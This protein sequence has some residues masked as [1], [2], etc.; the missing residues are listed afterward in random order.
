MVGLAG[1]FVIP[2]SVVHAQEDL[3]EQSYADWEVL[4]S[5]TEAAL[6]GGAAS[7]GLLREMRETIVHWRRVFSQAQ[8]AEQSR[9]TTVN[10]QLAALGPAVPEGVEEAPEIQDRRT[11]LLGQLALLQAPEL[12]ALEAHTRADGLIREID[13]ILRDREASRLS[14]RGPSPL[15]AAHWPGA[16]LEMKRTGANAATEI[17]VAWLSFGTSPELEENL[18][19]LIIYLMVAAVLLVRGRSWTEAFTLNVQ[20][21]VATGA[22]KFVGFFVSFG[23]VLLPVIGLIAL[24]RAL[25]ST[26]IF[27]LQGQLL[28]QSLPLMG[29]AIYGA[30]WLSVRLFPKNGNQI[31]V[32]N[33]SAPTNQLLRRYSTWFG[34]LFALSILLARTVEMEGY[35][36]EVRAVMFFPLFV[37]TGLLL[38]R[39]ARILR[40]GLANKQDDPD[41]TE[42]TNG[43]ENLILKLMVFISIV[44]PAAA[45]LGYFLVA[46]AIIFPSVLSIAL[47]GLILVLNGVFREIY[48]FIFGVSDENAREALVPTLTGIFLILIS[49]PL[50][51]LI[52]GAQVFDL[53]ELWTRFQEGIVI[54]DNRL[55][56]S[57]FVTFAAVFFVLFALTRLL[58]RTLK[59]TILPKTGIDIGGRTAI[60][61]G[62]GYVGMFLAAVLAVS[63]AGIDLSNLAIVA[64]ALSVGIG[65]GL[66]TIVSN[67]VSG[68]ILLIERPISEGDW[69]DVGG[70]MGYVRDISV[71]ATRIETFD[72]TDV[73]I[74]NS[75]LISG[76]VT[77][78]TRGNL[79]GRAIVPVGVAY[80]TDTRKVSNILTEIAEAHPLVAMNPRPSIVFKG[81][82]DSSL[83]FEIRAI[84][85]DV[86][87]ILV[88][89]TEL[90]HEI[91]RRFAQEGIEIPFP[92]RD[93]WLRNPQDMLPKPNA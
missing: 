92:Q 83:D 65:F 82:G 24:T 60:V 89:K 44:G 12:R 63:T 91:A 25:I 36:D 7:E 50:F 21:R 93:V 80:G 84:L 58:Q 53:V 48:A 51:A 85:R 38:F 40:Q 69:I 2:L 4:A 61:S 72:R 79:I 3:T 57:D 73:I 45:A 11:E 22:S 18:P 29:I 64:G 16:L 15:N 52:L 62:I 49:L 88:V 71:R 70:Q 47:I 8:G 54:G 41:A 81:F 14:E 27:G 35:S 10:R 6:S 37:L 46:D 76:I 17:P 77:N 31:G 87:F 55:Q 23:Q 9:I 19:L 90:N 75:D 42:S 20:D 74:P 33:L 67:F 30:R 86:N 43:L 1:L 59:T 66:Q 78:Y 68:I 34:I 56:P 28:L 32:L 26:G 39:T 5:R 13:A